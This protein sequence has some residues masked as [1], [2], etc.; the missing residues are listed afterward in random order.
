MD[1]T[2]LFEEHH[3]SLFRYLM[4][5]TGDADLAH[6]AAQE[7]FV[8]LVSKP[9]RDENPR[10]WLFAVATNVVR[11]WANTR[12]RHLVLL[13]SRAARVPTA[14]ALPDPE[15]ITTAN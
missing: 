1:A 12:K 11:G 13:E 15:E 3:G 5:L 9:P 14:D 8:R 4:R 10:A 2:Q 6:D 7:A